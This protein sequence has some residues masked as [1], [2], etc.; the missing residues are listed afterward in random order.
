MK[1]HFPKDLPPTIPPQ[2]DADEWDGLTSQQRLWRCLICAQEATK[3]AADAS[4]ELKQAYVDLSRHWLALARE[5][6]KAT[7]GSG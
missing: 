5:I 3:L 7:P 2:F 6:E 1:P 4:L